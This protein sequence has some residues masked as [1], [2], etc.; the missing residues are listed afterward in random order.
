[1]ELFNLLTSNLSQDEDAASFGVVSMAGGMHS[2]KAELIEELIDMTWLLLG[3]GADVN[4]RDSENKTPLH[5][6][7]LLSNDL[8]M[9]ETLCDNFADVNVV[10]CF[11]NTPLMAVCSQVPSL[12]PE[13][14]PHMASCVHKE[15]LVGKVKYLLSIHNLEVC[16]WAMFSY[17]CI[18]LYFIHSPLRFW[19]SQPIAHSVSCKTV[20]TL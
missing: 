15:C 11:G 1:M 8:R 2:T 3:H 14:Y 10:D 13:Q 20:G 4:V 7:L 12:G 5:S 9:A 16:S 17:L 6:T 19:K 18:I